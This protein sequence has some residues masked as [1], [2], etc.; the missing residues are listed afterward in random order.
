MPGQIET[1]W[2]PY[3]KLNTYEYLIFEKEAK[4]IQWKKE[5]VFNNGAYITVCHHVEH[6]KY[7][8]VYHHVQNSSPSGS[9]TST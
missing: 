3:I 7:A 8:R 4:T 1:I 5:S 9:K 2:R 6:Y